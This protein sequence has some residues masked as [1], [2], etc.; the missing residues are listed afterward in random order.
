[1]SLVQNFWPL[2][3]QNRQEFQGLD[4]LLES[5]VSDGEHQ[6]SRRRLTRPSTGCSVACLESLVNV[7][8]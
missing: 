6:N 3:K 2:R 1:M 7:R 4:F 8:R 5:V